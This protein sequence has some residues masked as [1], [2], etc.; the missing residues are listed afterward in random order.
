MEISN[1]KTGVVPNWGWNLVR[2]ALAVLLLT[3]SALKCWQLATE[4]VIG[5]GLLDSRWLLM[6][7]VEFELF[8]AILLLTNLWAK[9]SW[10]VALA[11]FGLFTC[12]SVCKALAGHASCGCFGRVPVNPWYTGAMDLAAVGSLLQ[13]RPKES[14][15]TARRATAVLVI[16][17]AVGLSAAY[18][19]VSYKPTTLS[20][21]G[22]TTVILKPETWVGKRFPLLSYIDI[23]DRLRDGKWLIVLY[24]YRCPDCLDALP[25]YERLASDLVTRKDG[26]R[27]A[28]IEVP[29]YSDE[30]SVALTKC[31]LGKL[32]DSKE[33]FVRT[34]L[35]VEIDD[36]IVDRV[37]S[38]VSANS[39]A[40]FGLS[41]P[42]LLFMMGGVLCIG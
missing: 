4:P 31:A 22:D 13:W 17:L 7:T 21:A 5:T 23:G 41:T 24:H 26:R 42:F 9:P 18:A 35:E 32:H 38:S 28:L 37:G 40:S 29:P 27:I 11:C 6:A 19:I 14:F 36:G 3:A 1:G 2:Y 39:C 8:L 16:W 30:S 15:F 34:P 12:V 20:D 33:W 25:K 10:A